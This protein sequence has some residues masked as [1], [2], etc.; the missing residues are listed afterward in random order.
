MKNQTGS[1]STK[2]KKITNFNQSKNQK[3][4]KIFSTFEEIQRTEK[5][6]LVKTNVE[7]LNQELSFWLPLS[8]VEI[9]ENI[10][11]VPADVWEKK[12]AELKLKQ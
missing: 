6:I 8:K 10:L 12:L 11:S 9:S 3:V 5:A 7:E 4:M 1:K 2:S